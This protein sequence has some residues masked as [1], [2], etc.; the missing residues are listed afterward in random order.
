M[1]GTAGLVPLLQPVPAIEAKLHA[2]QHSYNKSC[3]LLTGGAFFAS[4]GKTLNYCVAAGLIWIGCEKNQS[5]KKKALQDM[6]WAFYL[7]LP[8]FLNL[9]NLQLGEGIQNF[10]QI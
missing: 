8:R 4:I 7:T 2:L 3:L 10:L 5:A 1:P 6:R 9:G